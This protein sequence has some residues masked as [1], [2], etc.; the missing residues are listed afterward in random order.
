MSKCVNLDARLMRSCVAAIA[1][2]VALAGC[3]FGAN[4]ASADSIQYQSYQRSSQTEACAAKPGETP[5]QASW[6]SDSSWKPSWEQWANGGKGG[7]TCTRS[8]TWARTPVASSGGGG[9]S[10][11]GACETGGPYVVGGIGPGC[12]LVF[13][14]SGGLTY[15]M[16]PKTWS[17]SSSDDSPALEWCSNS[18][19]DV[20]GA[21]GTA[22]GTGSANTTAMQSPACA[23]GVA[24][25]A[26]AYAGGG[27]T[28]WFVPSKDEFNE[29]FTYSQVGGFNTATYG[30]VSASYWTSSQFSAT[31]AW[32]QGGGSGYPGNPG[33]STQLRVRPIRAF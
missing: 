21:V 27:L 4:F 23:S 1:A 31:N 19:S 14:I 17:G 25:S 7:W 15:E 18:S 20:A 24:I 10:A 13:L 8:I 32:R 29:M 16:A 30:F 11:I 9:G 33:K 12:G 28:D 6:G 26:R 22:I 5:W 2:L 3:L